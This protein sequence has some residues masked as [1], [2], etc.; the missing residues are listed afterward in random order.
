MPFFLSLGSKFFETIRMCKERELVP[1][2]KFT[3]NG[4]KVYR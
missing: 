3:R 4:G 2:E 1:L